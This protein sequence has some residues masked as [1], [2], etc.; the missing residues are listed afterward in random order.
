[1]TI[2]ISA[3]CIHFYFV[4]YAD[5]LRLTSGRGDE[6]SGI[7]H[8]GDGLFELRCTA[9]VVAFETGQ[10]SQPLPVILTLLAMNGVR[11]L[12]LESVQNLG[13]LGR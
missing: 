1:M 5:L 6:R 2:D 13:R 4:F 12:P 9:G 10:T 3:T 8:I 11:R 7:Y